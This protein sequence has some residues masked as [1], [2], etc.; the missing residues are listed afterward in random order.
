MN[1]K[2]AGGYPPAPPPFLK[3]F[4]PHFNAGV[5]NS[6]LIKLTDLETKVKA[7]EKDRIALQK[8]VDELKKSLS[9]Y[10]N[11]FIDLSN[12]VSRLSKK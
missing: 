3:F 9:T 7:G 8:E 5:L 6:N 2:I 1:V 4:F 10:H 12:T 11:K